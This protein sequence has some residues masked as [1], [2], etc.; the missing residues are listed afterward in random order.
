M[1]KKIYIPAIML[2]MLLAY[3]AGF[4]HAKEGN[5]GS[6]I[7]SFGLKLFQ[8]VIK[9]EEGKNVMISPLSV[10]MALTMVY[11]G[12]R[13]ET[14]E[15]MSRTLETKG[16]SMNDINESYKHLIESLTSLDSAV[17]FQ[18][19]NSIWYRQNFQVEKDFLDIND[20]FFNARISPCNLLHPGTADTINAWVDENTNGKIPRIVEKPLSAYLV[21][22]L[23]NAIYFHG[24]WAAKFDIEDT[25]DDEF[26]LS[27][28]SRV[29]CKMMNQE[30]Q[31]PYFEN[32]ILQAVEL[33]YGNGAFSMV[34]L[35]PKSGVGVDELIGLIDDGKLKLWTGSLQ[36]RQGTF[37][38]P[39]F[40]IEYD[41]DLTEILR[42]MGMD[43]AFSS[44]AD[45]S[46]INK[47]KQ[48]FISFVKHKTYV[49]VDEEGT[50][51][52]AV[53]V[54]GIEVA[55]APLESFVM[56]LDRPFIFLIRE[57]ASGTVIFLG[58]IT[59]PT[60]G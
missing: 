30:K 21:M 35:L 44:A 53:T 47:N 55:A 5:V 14:R 13:G 40:K 51:A 24:N 26:T 39:R 36:R 15:A 22:L 3:F 58:K 54:V 16:I 49:D 29:A 42:S 2:A 4:C 52:A 34:I 46:G 6:S 41:R 57:T 37:S 25:I 50:E 1:S 48:L 60:S 56:R 23:I 59:D 9:T 32:D 8:E 45:F 43:V 20:S 31:F 11:N 18:I 33:P 17:V 19:A 10:S 38:M 27:D 28:G 12:A 7:N